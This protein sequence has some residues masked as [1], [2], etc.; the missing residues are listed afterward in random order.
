VAEKFWKTL[1]VQFCNQAGEEVK[2]EVEAIYP[3]E[4]LP[5]QP[6]R[7]AVHRCSLG[8]ACNTRKMKGCVWSGTN[9]GY[10]PFE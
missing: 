2:L 7:L 1:K 10:D 8:M 3:P 5:D 9:P 6:P 4:V